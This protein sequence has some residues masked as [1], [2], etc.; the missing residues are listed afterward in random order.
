MY[1]E[2]TDRIN[3]FG[4]IHIFDFVRNLSKKIENEIEEKDKEYILG[5]DEE[6]FKN[7][8]ID[9]YTL[10]PLNVNFDSETIGEP[11]VSKEWIVNK[12]W[13]ET[14]EKEVYTFT[15]EYRFTGSAVLF[16]V[17]PTTFTI[18]SAEIDVN[19]K[20]GMVSFSFALYNREPNEFNRLKNKFRDRAF[21]NLSNI[22]L[23]VLDW[24]N[25]LP[26][27]VN[28]YF[29]SQ[30]D[31][32][33][34]ENDFFAAINVKVDENTTSVFAAPTIKK[35]IIPQPTIPKDKKYSSMPTMSKEMYDD[36]LKV[37]YDSGKSMERKP[38]LY[39]DKDEEGLRDQFLFILETRYEGITATGETFN[40]SGK[41]DIILKY[42]EDGSNLFVAECK[43][44]HG[45]AEFLEGINQLFERYLTW[46][47]SKVALLIF[48]TNKKFTNV[49]KTIKKEIKSHPYFIEEKGQRREISFSYIFRLPQDEEKRVFLEILAFHYDK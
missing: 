7:Y 8:L 37:I 38:S 31:K 34:K 11:S 30:K 21:A 3:S 36:T 10:E 17:K 42:A 44:W 5:V 41:A 18:T 45:C 12:A 4:E 27:K 49:I 20:T 2:Y 23:D 46:H 43:F 29:Q 26:E 9:K 6:K 16:G 14:Y 35:K 40:R 25:K 13:E 19:E 32:Y 1:H 48:V 39:K 47:D 33:K 15:V 28:S 22:N 24:N